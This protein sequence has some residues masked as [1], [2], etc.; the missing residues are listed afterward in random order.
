MERRNVKIV[1]RME[2]EGNKKEKIQC[3]NNQW[4]GSREKRRK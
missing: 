4:T 3:R 1:H 2:R